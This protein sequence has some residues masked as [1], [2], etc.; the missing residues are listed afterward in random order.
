MVKQSAAYM[1]GLALLCSPLAQA[2]VAVNF[3][4]SAPKDWFEI[5]N[6]GACALENLQLEID[7]RNSVGQLI[8]DTTATGAG[9]DVFQPFEIRAGD[10][11]LV[12]SLEVNDG[13]TGLSIAIPKL[14]AGSSVSFTIDVDDTL[15]GSEMGMIRV[16]GA[17][18][19]NAQVNLT[20]GD[21][22]PVSAT[23]DNASTATVV[24]PP[25]PAA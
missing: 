23:F 9:V 20:L 22:Q 21:Q 18:I 17:E 7:L 8:F 14:Q 2:N 15:V 24:L 19:E 16:T 6:V 13:D 1:L 10:L 25:C 11:K 3:V 12:S 5:Q 4:E